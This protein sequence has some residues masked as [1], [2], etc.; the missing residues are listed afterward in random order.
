MICTDDSELY[1]N[2]KLIRAHG[3]TRN[4]SEDFRRRK[5]A[6]SLID[7]FYGIYAFYDLAY[8]FRPTEINGFIGNQQIAFWDE[9]IRKRED[10]FDK[11]HKATLNNDDIIKLKTG[12]MN[13]VS[14]FGFP[15]LFKNKELFEKYKELFEKEN[16]EIRPIIAGNISKQP[17][18]KKYKKNKNVC[19]NA[20]KIHRNG[21]YFGNNP[22]M[23]YIEIA[24]IVNILKN[25]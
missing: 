11:F 5:R 2:L 9:I 25:T 1:E 19:P 15:L 10:N 6:D 8:N 24:R 17:F 16:I 22:E 4:N 14:N 18:Y 20:E 12:D 3:W 13:V 23:N 21:F 7:D